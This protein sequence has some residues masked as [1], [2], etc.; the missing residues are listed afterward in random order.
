MTDVLQLVHL[1]YIKQV[2]TYGEY[3]SLVIAVSWGGLG[4]PMHIIPFPNV[5]V[6]FKVG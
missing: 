2:V 5:E 1:T 4:L 3:A 6:V